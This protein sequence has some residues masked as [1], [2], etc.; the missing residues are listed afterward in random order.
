[1]PWSQPASANPRQLL[2]QLLGGRPGKL[3]RVHLPAFVL[4]SSFLFSHPGK[5]TRVGPTH[6]RADM[7]L[8]NRS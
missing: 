3:T 8:V 2:V 6:V 1:M 4:S 5:G 7:P